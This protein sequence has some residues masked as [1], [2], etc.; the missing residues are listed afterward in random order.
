MTT[1]GYTISYFLGLFEGSRS[2]QLP[3]KNAVY[4][5]ISPKLGAKSVRAAVLNKWLECRTTA[6]VDGT[7]QFATYGSTPRARLLKALKNRKKT[8]SV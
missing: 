1:K 7:G 4:S 6:I 8:G 2:R 3:N 5:F